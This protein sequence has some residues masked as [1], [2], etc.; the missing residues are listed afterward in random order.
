VHG[1]SIRRFRQSS[2]WLPLSQRR[3]SWPQY[4]P[5]CRQ[6]IV[7]VRVTVRAGCCTVTVVVRPRRLTVTVLAGCGVG[8]LTLTVT[9]TVGVGFPLVREVVAP[10]TAGTVITKI[11]ATPIAARAVSRPFISDRFCALLRW[12]LLGRGACGVITPSMVSLCGRV[13]QPS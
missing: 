11:R 12:L 13:P 2:E 1:R 4:R 7:T 9:V 8:T 3:Q 10:R 5:G 6:W